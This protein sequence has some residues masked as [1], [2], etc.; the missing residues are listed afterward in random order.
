[1]ESI[2]NYNVFTLGYDLWMWKSPYCIDWV[3]HHPKQNIDKPQDS[4][5]VT[6]I[7]KNEKSKKVVGVKKIKWN[8]KEQISDINC[9]EYKKLNIFNYLSEGISL[10][11][12]LA[13]EHEIIKQQFKE[14]NLFKK[15][16]RKSSKIENLKNFKYSLIDDSVYSLFDNYISNVYGNDRFLEFYR[17]RVSGDIKNYHPHRFTIKRDFDYD[18]HGDLIEGISTEFSKNGHIDKIIIK[19]VEN[20]KLYNTEEEE[21]SAA[22]WA[23]VKKGLSSIMI[24]HEYGGNNG[25]DLCEIRSDAYLDNYVVTECWDEKINY[26]FDDNL[27]YPNPSSSTVEYDGKII[28]EWKYFYDDDKLIKMNLENKINNSSSDFSVEYNSTNNNYDD[29]ISDVQ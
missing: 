4:D 20:I 27:Y 15:I 29:E 17:Q 25:D 18:F 6:I 5:S 2:E 9:C 23:S 28:L 19:A 7:V 12:S 21:L 16:E 1:M 24:Y 13:L 11:R 22:M 26:Y 3:F 10:S 8:K 14:N